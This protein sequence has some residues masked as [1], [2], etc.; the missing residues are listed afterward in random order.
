MLQSIRGYS[1]SEIAARRLKIIRF[2]ESY[3]EA[4]SKEAFGADRRLIH[5][6]K[7]RLDE[8]RGRLESLIPLSTRPHR[9]RKA[10]YPLVLVDFIKNLRWNH[11]RLGKEKIKPLLDEYCRRH[12]LNT[13]SIST[14][15]NL[16]RRNH[17]FLQGQGR[18]YHSTETAQRAAK[19]RGKMKR[20]RIRHLPKHQD[21]GHIFSDT[22]E[23]ITDGIKDYF[24]SA[25][26]SRLKFALTLNYKRLTSTNMKDF[27]ERFKGAYPAGPI[28]S[29]QTDNGSENLGEFD[30]ALKEDKIPHL[31][32]YPGCP[33][34]NA[35]IE[36]YNR[37]I[38]EEFINNHL[39]ILADKTLFHRALSDYL[40]FYNTRRV[41]K[42]LGNVTPMDYLIRE[43][44]MSQMYLTRTPV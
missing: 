25:I 8:N 7:K 34:V 33:K 9:T 14:I 3:G 42:S 1:I 30:R 4:A 35:Y 12:H 26:D 40:I 2:Y 23:R 5:Q 24:M 28:R 38:Q 10:G 31:F 22:V 21:F 16:I 32:I 6:W 19:A 37:T 11:P 17:L 20:L 15:G 29:W 13:L 39:D 27:Y 43:K 36:R 44:G 18:I 41:H